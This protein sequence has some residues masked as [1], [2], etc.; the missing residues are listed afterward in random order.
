MK[1]VSSDSA[2]R[3]KDTAGW[4]KNRPVWLT[5]FNTPPFTYPPF[6]LLTVARAWK[7]HGLEAS[8]RQL[9]IDR[10]G[11]LA[12]RAVEHDVALVGMSVTAGPPL[13]AAV[14]AGRALRKAGIPVVWG[15]A[16]PTTA[17][18]ACLSFDAAD[19]VVVGPGE[20]GT[21]AL[22]ETLNTF[23]PETRDPM[24]MSLEPPPYEPSPVPVYPDPSLL[25][26][27]APYLPPRP[28]FRGRA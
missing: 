2:R 9:E 4:L 5:A 13:A 11:E 8:V 24:V 10:A 23:R 19:V 3:Q 7:R 17:P 20:H 6:G 21:E 1:T 25:D 22:L 28:P 16:M 27:P 14:A 26:D 12:D 18:W 15:G